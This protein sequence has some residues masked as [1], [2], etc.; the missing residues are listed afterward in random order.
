MTEL[1]TAAT[2]AESA[3]RDAAAAPAA[4]HPPLPKA[5]IAWQIRAREALFEQLARGEPVRFLASHLPVLATLRPGGTVNLANKG[6][7]LLPKRE[8][9]AGYTELYAR[10][11]REC[12]DR[13]REQT[14]AARIAAARALLRRPDHID[15]AALGSL[16][17]FEGETLHNI[18]RDP[19][20]ALLFTGEG[21]RYP[22]FQVEARARIA[23]PGDPVY[24]FLRAARLLFEAEPFHLAQP[25][26]P[27]GYELQVTAVR[28]KTPRRRAA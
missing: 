27:C 12:R 20:V 23:G 13:P 24:E 8:H 18:R 16:E 4:P 22:S 10:V 6:V 3:G 11:L 14:L 21:P 9:L 1:S 17:I 5:F 2:E 7:G 25:A 28:E 19:R 26:Y 15:G